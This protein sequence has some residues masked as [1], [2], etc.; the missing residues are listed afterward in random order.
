M[1]IVAQCCRFQSHTGKGILGEGILNLST[2]H[3]TSGKTGGNCAFYT[4]ELA[5]QIF[6]K[7]TWMKE[8]MYLLISVLIHPKPSLRGLYRPAIPVI[9]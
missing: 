2:G 6:G 3:S 1:E 8:K 4:N 9:L 7:L 5:A